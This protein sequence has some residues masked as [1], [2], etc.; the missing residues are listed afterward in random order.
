VS[1]ICWRRGPLLQCAPLPTHSLDSRGYFFEILQAYVRDGGGLQHSLC[2]MDLQH[3]TTSESILNMKRLFG[4]N[5]N[6]QNILPVK[7]LNTEIISKLLR[8][9]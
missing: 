4:Y 6:L 2:L 9:A 8:S 5:K 1:I 3:V 7:R